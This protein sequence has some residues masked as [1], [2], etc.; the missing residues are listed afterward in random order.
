MWVDMRHRSRNARRGSAMLEAALIYGSFMF[1]LIA[2]IDVGYTMFLHQT[3]VER[4]RGAARY[5]VARTFD[6]TAIQNKVLYNSPTIPSGASPIFGLQTSNVSVSETPATSMGAPSWL[7][8]RITGWR[9]FRFTPNHAG[10]PTGQ[11]ISVT[12]PMETP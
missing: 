5:G 10:Q 4:A 9:F 3:L 12:L 7:N 8:V 11:D 1:M 6:A 2:I